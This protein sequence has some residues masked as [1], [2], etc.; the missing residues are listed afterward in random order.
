MFSKGSAAILPVALLVLIWWQR[1][2]IRRVDL[3]RTAPFFLIAVALTLVNIQFQQRG[4]AEAI[5]TASF[6]ERCAEAG[7]AVWFY[8]CKAL[9][10]INLVFIYPL[11]KIDTGS[12]LWWFPMCAAVMVT[13]VLFWRRSNIWVRNLFAAWLFFGVA[14]GPN[15]GFVDVG[16]MQHSL[17]ADHYQHIAL[18]A[19]VALAAAWIVRVLRLPSAPL[20]KI[21]MVGRIGR[22]PDR[23]LLATKSF[24]RNSDDAVRGNL[25]E[26][27]GQLDGA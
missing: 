5:R 8:L 20:W 12:L 9:V 10:P 17:V 1:R 13:A 25:K 4:F 21:C 24:V 16:F 2:R 15:L 3:L 26:K 23:P 22:R 7:A 11:W 19:V 27:S 6:A 14:L 18:I